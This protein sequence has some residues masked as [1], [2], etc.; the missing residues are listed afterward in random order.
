LNSGSLQAEVR[1]RR[2]MAGAMLVTG[3]FMAV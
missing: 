2:L 1:E 3:G